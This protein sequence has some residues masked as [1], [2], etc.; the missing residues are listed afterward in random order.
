M[1]CGAEPVDLGVIV[2]NEMLLE[3]ALRDAADNCDA[4]IT[5]GG[6]SMGDYD[7]VKAVLSRIADMSWFQIAMKP[8]KPFAFGTLRNDD[9][10]DVPVF[11]LPGNPVSSL[12]SFE[13]ITRPALE[14]MMHTADSMTGRRRVKGIIDYAVARQPDGKIHFDRCVASWGADG[15][16][17]VTRVA[18][19]ASRHRKRANVVRHA[20]RAWR[21]E[22]GERPVRTAVCDFLL[23]AQHVEAAVL[24]VRDRASRA[25]LALDV[26]VAPDVGQIY[27]DEGRVRQIFYNLLSNAIRFAPPGGGIRFELSRRDGHL[28]IDLSDDGPGV[29][30]AD[31]A[32]I[33]DEAVTKALVE[34]QQ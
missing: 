30:P 13:L 12:V 18:A 32:R 14:V 15:R 34:E 6:V 2:D 25:R 1:S 11:G 7:V 19:Q 9:G 26:A 5:S 23:L 22:V 8:A 20:T 33:F 29:A 3:Q 31:Q 16:I 27:A 28:L 4:I 21:D 24:G 17:H 10:V